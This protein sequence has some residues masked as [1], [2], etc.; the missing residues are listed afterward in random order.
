M[1]TV[2][3]VE[4]G[5]DPLRSKHAAREQEQANARLRGT[6]CT[7]SCECKVKHRGNQPECPL[8]L[9]GDHWGSLDSYLAKIQGRTT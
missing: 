5:I 7:C 1:A 2:E 8:C 9:A 4:R 3:D 6:P